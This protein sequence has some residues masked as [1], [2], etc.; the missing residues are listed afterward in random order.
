MITLY[1]DNC[2]NILNNFPN[3]IDLVITSPPYD[4]LRDYKGY[5][6]NFEKIARL[7]S[8]SLKLGGVIVWIVNDATIKGSE[9]LTS[10]KQAIFFVEECGLNLH[11]T[12]IWEKGNFSNPSTNR[13]HQIFDYMFV[14]SKGKPKTFNPICD[15]KN[16]YGPCFG[17]NTKR[18]TAGQMLEYKKPKS[19]EFGMRKNIWRSLTVGQENPGKSNFHP[20]AF[21]EKLISDHIKSWTNEGDI[22]MDPLMGGGTTG[23]VAKELNRD[24]IGIEVSKEYFDYAEKRING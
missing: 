7:L 14:F 11:D 6:F 3:S 23:K 10:F 5:S 19:R 2:E 17:K 20:A 8:Y 21:P 9:S 24:F 16:K 12:M 18:Q 4:N 1:N 13:Y 22:V 15:V